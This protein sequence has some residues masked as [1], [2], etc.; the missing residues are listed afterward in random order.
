MVV[1]SDQ[2]PGEGVSY[3]LQ[4][5]LSRAPLGEPD[6]EATCCIGTESQHSLVA[7]VANLDVLWRNGS[8]SG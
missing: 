1:D 5:S 7:R 4:S 8:L 2:C 3:L 6:S